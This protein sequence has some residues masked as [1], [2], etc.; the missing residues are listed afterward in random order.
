VYVQPYGNLAYERMQD[1][2][3]EM[4]R[5]YQQHEMNEYRRGAEYY[6]RHF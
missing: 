1:R 3:Y 6:G 4:Q 5:R 2:Q